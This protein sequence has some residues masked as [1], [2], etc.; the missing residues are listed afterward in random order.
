MVTY[1]TVEGKVFQLGRQGR[2]EKHDPMI[3]HVAAAPP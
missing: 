3:Q 1:L 2:A